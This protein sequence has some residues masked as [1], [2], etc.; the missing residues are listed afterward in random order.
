M[1]QSLHN[2]MPLG[3]SL[4]FVSSVGVVIGEQFVYAFVVVFFLGGFVE[5]WWRPLTVSKVWDQSNA[6]S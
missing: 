3:R 1:L 6:D 4:A 5:S 2:A